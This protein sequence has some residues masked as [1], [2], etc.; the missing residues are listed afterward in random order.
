MNYINNSDYA[1]NIAYN[2]AVDFAKSHYEN[3]P[4]VSLFIPK[5]L[6]KH[7]AVVYQFARQ[8][9]DLADEGSAA[10]KTRIERLEQYEFQLKNCLQGNYENDFWSV[11][12]NTITLLKLTPKYFYD[13]LSAFKQ[14]V[15]KK[16]YSSF[17]DLLNYCERSANPVGRII[18]E[19]FGVSDKE[20]LKYSDAICT[21][22][23][24]TNF[25]QDVSVDI[26]KGRI[27]IPL[28]EMKT[29]GV[30]ENVFEL[31]KNNTNFI[32]LLKYQIDR[33]K[34][35]FDEG[36]K[37]IPFLPDNL[38]KQIILTILGGKEILR[39]I[40]QIDYNVL[41]ERPSLGKFDFIKIFFKAILGTWKIK[42]D[43]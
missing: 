33:T 22:L 38:K 15:T 12:N 28:D 25:Y 29:F 39:K 41:Q 7:V 34:K 21:A 16:S 4:V 40:E 30:N 24:L 19:I 3:F 2:R 31:K 5:E 10:S 1:L 20:A 32:L 18:L 43:R 14:D 26:V 35:L 17:D 23:Q 13:L 42:P 8:A 27:Y 6:R 9:D 37:L 11:L 36:W